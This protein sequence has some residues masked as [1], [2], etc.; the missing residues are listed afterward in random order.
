MLQG[1]HGSLAVS[2]LSLVVAK[3]T[4]GSANALGVNGAARARGRLGKAADRRG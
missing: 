2:G 1:R 4:P 3:K